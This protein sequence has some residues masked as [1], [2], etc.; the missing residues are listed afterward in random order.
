MRTP[1]K[2]AQKWGFRADFIAYVVGVAAQIVVWWLVTPEHFFWPLWS[3]I[4]W[5]VGLGF[6]A[7]AVYRP[8][9]PGI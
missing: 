6:H 2:N 4:G 3:M 7:W 1:S 8:S 5:G 9:R